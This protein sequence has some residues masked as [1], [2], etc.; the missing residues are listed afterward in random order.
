MSI[1]IPKKINGSDSKAQNRVGSP[2]RSFVS[3]HNTISAL[4]TEWF[5]LSAQ[6]VLWIKTIPHLNYP[7][8]DDDSFR[9]QWN[10]PVISSPK[11]AIPDA[12][13]YGAAHYGSYNGGNR[14][15]IELLEEYD[16]DKFWCQYR[17][18]VALEKFL[19][20]S[21]STYYHDM[22]LSHLCVPLTS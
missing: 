9:V 22:G 15:R 3:T 18:P 2:R 19:A 21:R 17:L 14:R 13:A 16:V 10:E 8:K 12:D 11:D 6:A 4:G 20:V 5:R 7:G 1:C